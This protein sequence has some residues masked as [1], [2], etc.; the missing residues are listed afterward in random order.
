MPAP[1][2]LSDSGEYAVRHNPFV[3]Y[4]DIQTTSQCNNDVPYTQLA[5]DLGSAATTPNYAFI[6]PNLID[7][8]HDGTI[9]QGDTWLQ[10]NISAYA[11]WCVLNNSLL[12]VTF[13]EDDSLHANRIVT[14]FYGPMVVPGQ[15]PQPITHY[16]ILRTIEDMYSLPHDAATVSAA[17]VTG[18][19]VAPLC[20]ANCDGSAAAPVLNAN[21]FQ[22]FLNA[23]ANSDSYANCDG[24]T[25][26]PVLN[27][28][29]FQCFLNQ[30]AY[31]CP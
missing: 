19:W 13:D 29:D 18:I 2:T 23:F 11:N 26:D 17:P 22:C 28:N 25:A 16:N 31:G 15:Y 30:F 12:I 6:T 21:D 14:L 9:A 27:G 5:T 3:Y 20:Y 4:T 1:C 10:N 24:S 7:D 8:M